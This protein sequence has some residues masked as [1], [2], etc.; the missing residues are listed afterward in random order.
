M[1]VRSIFLFLLAGFL[2]PSRSLAFPQSL[3]SSIQDKYSLTG[4]VVNSVTGEAIRGALVQIY[5]NGQSSRLTGPD[6]KFQF[7]GLFAGQTPITVRKPGFFSEEELENGLPKFRR[8]AVDIGPDVS[9]AILKLV[10]EGVIYGRITGDDGEPIENLPVQLVVQRL[11]N[12][13]KVWQD[14]QG[15]STNEDGEFRIA[16]LQPG[17][18]YLSAGPSGSSV[19]IASG[20]SNSAALGFPV[21]YYPAGSDI[22]LASPIPMVPGKRAEINFTLSPQPCFRVAGTI[23]GYAAGQFANL[24]VLNSAGKHLASGYRF[25]PA[26]GAFR[27]P[28]I[29]SGTYTLLANAPPT[30]PQTGPG[31]FLTAVLP[32]TVNADLSGIHIAL[33]PNANIPIRMRVISSRTGSER[34]TQQ[35]NYF[36]AYVQLVSHT[37]GMSESRHGSQQVGERGSAS[38]ELQNIPPGIYGVEIN[39]NG[40][41]YVQSATS[42]PTNLLQSDLSIPAGGAPQPIEITLRDDGA[43]ISGTVS[44]DNHPFTAT[45]LAFSEHSSTPPIIQLTDPK[46]F[47][48][49]PFLPP[50]EYKFLAV[51]HPEQLEYRNPDVMRKYLVRASGITLSPDQKAKIELEAVKVEE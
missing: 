29:P 41:L 21:V 32:L 23:I 12:G 31:R 26:T 27:I 36:P 46:G 24:Q 4:T 45:V 44:L 18:Y 5:M 17:T 33:L 43:S 49:M 48:Q 35:E 47:F 30:A 2:S 40:L 37:S 7:D 13:R 34:F 8:P 51:D 38:L 15:G 39:P 9:P 10:P 20:S 25:D 14:R 1:V 3:R 42:G 16:E 19:P 28:C 50:G 6:G 11:E 22:S